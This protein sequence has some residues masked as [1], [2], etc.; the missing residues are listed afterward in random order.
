MR[1][2]ISLSSKVQI[3]EDIVSR[4]LQGQMVLL[5]LKTNLY[6]GLDHMGAKIWHLLNEQTNK[7]KLLK[8]VLN[9]LVKEYDV[10]EAQCTE[11]LLNFVGMLKEKDLI[12]I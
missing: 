2:T 7:H 12:E 10:S 8:D 11:D 5:N 4:N 6:C 3:N 9:E 1:E